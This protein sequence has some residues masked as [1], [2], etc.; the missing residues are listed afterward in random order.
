M[1]GRRNS[2]PCPGVGVYHRLAARRVSIKDKLW[3]AMQATPMTA[4]GASLAVAQFDVLV[5]A[6]PRQPKGLRLSRLPLNFPQGATVRTFAASLVEGRPAGRSGRIYA[7][8]ATRLGAGVGASALKPSL[9]R[10]RR[11]DT[12]LPCLTKNPKAHDANAGSHAS[13]VGDS[14]PARQ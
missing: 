9:M 4:T 8:F 10:C 3:P 6:L 5:F 13:S 1:Y 2:H 14:L 11:S 12:A 7:A